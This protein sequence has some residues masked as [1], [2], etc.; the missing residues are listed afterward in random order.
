MA[1]TRLM[2]ADEFMRITELGRFDL[3]D[4]ELIRTSPAGGR[5]GEV[6]S[7]SVF[8]LMVYAG[9]T[10]PGKVYTAEASFLQARNPDVV[11]RRMPRSCGPNGFLRSI[12]GSAIC[13]SRRML[14]SRSSRRR[15]E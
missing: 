12:S 8:A 11:L 9:E 13:R 7:Q 1:T 5:Q 2:T 6:A 14:R 4:G 15:I 10:L 3:I